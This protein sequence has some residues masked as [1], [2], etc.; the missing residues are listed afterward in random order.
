MLEIGIDNPEHLAPCG[1]PAADYRRRQSALALSAHDLDAR[2][3][4]RQGFGQFPSTVGTVVVDDDNLIAGAERISKDLREAADH[5]WEILGF[6]VGGQY[7][8]QANICARAMR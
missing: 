6:V 8:R 2:I 1:L 5:L 7:D 4:R 3:L